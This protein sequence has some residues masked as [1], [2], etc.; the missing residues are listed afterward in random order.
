MAQGGGFP[1]G[2]SNPWTARTTLDF[3]LWG[4]SSR[5]P[6][7]ELQ[8]LLHVHPG[9]FTPQG[10]E[11]LRAEQKYGPSPQKEQ[12]RSSTSGWPRQSTSQQ[13]CCENRKQHFTRCPLV[14]AFSNKGCQV[15][16]EAKNS[17]E[18]PERDRATAHHSALRFFAREPGAKLWAW[19]QEGVGSGA[20]AQA[21][22]FSKTSRGE[23]V[24]LSDGFQLRRRVNG[25]LLS[26]THEQWISVVCIRKV[27]GLLRG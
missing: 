25:Y 19:K 12:K 13:I 11:R 23:S 14:F 18:T 3:W 17:R 10:K 7:D 20:L 1:F 5:N 2:F 21:F 24:V 27:A 8:A 4:S 6:L 16:E 22:F 15:Q 26:G 9:L